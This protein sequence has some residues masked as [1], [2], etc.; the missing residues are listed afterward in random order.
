MEAGAVAG[1]TLQRGS[2]GGSVHSPRLPGPPVATWLHRRRTSQGASRRPQSML[3]VIV[4]PGLVV[5]NE[6]R[7]A[8]LWLHANPGFTHR[9]GREEWARPPSPEDSP[10]RR[11]GRE[12]LHQVQALVERVGRVE[13]VMSKL[14]QRKEAAGQRGLHAVL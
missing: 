10:S 12:V 14:S 5:R 1:E 8:A 4:L 13:E 7:S 2:S 9:P 11:P 6:R 3:G